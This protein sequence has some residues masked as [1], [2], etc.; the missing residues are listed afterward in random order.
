MDIPT[1]MVTTR[2][3]SWTRRPPSVSIHPAD[4]P[5]GP[6][7]PPSDRGSSAKD[8]DSLRDEPRSPIFFVCSCL[9]PTMRKPGSNVRRC[10]MHP[11]GGVLFSFFL[12][13]LTRL[14]SQKANDY[15]RSCS[16]YTPP[17]T[18]RSRPPSPIEEGVEYYFL[19]LV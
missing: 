9:P 13:Y 8:G 1:Q 14:I 3:L 15:H 17:A 4:F 2:Y 5:D 16:T 18:F 6:S 19:V 7:R 12:L 10:Y 11:I